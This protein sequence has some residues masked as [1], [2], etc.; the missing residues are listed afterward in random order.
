MFRR[1]MIVL[2]VLTVLFLAASLWFGHLHDEIST[3]HISKSSEC[4][5]LPTVEERLYCDEWEL[6][7]LRDIKNDSATTIEVSLNATIAT[8]F[9]MIV[10]GVARWVWRAKKRA[11]S[12]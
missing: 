8:L 10:S 7:L 9:L 11:S 2:S 12:D 4:R 5:S 6:S 1:Y 3:E